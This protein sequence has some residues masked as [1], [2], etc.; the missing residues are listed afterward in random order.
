MLKSSILQTAGKSLEE[1][2]LVF[3]DPEDIP[4][5]SPM[6]D[7]SSEKVDKTAELVEKA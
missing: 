3:M 1:V 6:S 5:H 4:N 2:D 7:V